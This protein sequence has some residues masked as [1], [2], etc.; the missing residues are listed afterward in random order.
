MSNLR[1]KVEGL[2]KTL[3]HFD[4]VARNVSEA[5]EQTAKEGAVEAQA[6]ARE[7][8]PQK[9]GRLRKSIK[10]KRGR[11]GLT[12]LVRPRSPVAHLQEY[13]TKRGVKPKW[14][15]RRTRDKIVPGVQRKILSKVERAV[16]S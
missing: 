1:I 13:G 2:D 11:Y 4:L 14:Y 16:R 8:A 10:M 12:Y 15:M 3:S 6:R 5:I 9:T 7:L